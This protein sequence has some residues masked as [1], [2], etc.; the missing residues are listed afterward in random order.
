MHELAI[1]GFA[2]PLGTSP[3]Y[4]AQ[5]RSPGQTRPAYDRAKRLLDLA[6]GIAVMPFVLLI[7]GLC[8]LAIMLESRGRVF[9]HEQWTGAGGHPF[10][11]WKLRTTAA[12]RA[13][14]TEVG[15]DSL[16]H[17]CFGQIDDPQLTRLGRVLRTLRIDQLPRIF[18]VLRGEMSLV[19]P[20]PTSLAA[21]Q[22]AL[23]HTAR[24]DMKPGI[25]GYWQIS[26]RDDL[27][28]DECLR[29][30]IAYVRNHTLALDV[31]ILL[32]T[33]AVVVRSGRTLVK[34]ALDIAVA[35][36]LLVI[37]APAMLVIA[38]AIQ[39]TSPGPI[40]FRQVRIGKRGR[41]FEIIKFRTMRGDAES[42]LATNPTL[43]ATYVANDFKLPPESDPRITPFG[44]WLRI[45]SLDELPQLFNVLRGEMS[46]VG[47]RPIVPA[48][49]AHYGN[50]SAK[51]YS[52]LPGLTGAWQV[53]G[54]CEL[55]YP[56]RCDVE[57]EY[58]RTWSLREDLFI[59]VRTV[60]AVLS[61]RGAV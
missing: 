29:L 55:R 1:R 30:D 52:V 3:W 31:E 54:R 35:G 10:D 51:F 7:L 16:G 22:H 33:V 43:H 12:N 6:V 42:V 58:I 17:A 28:F 34:R 8:A 56:E 9:V 40:F 2:G 46:L 24:F 19:G 60:G 37:L 23:W 4:H 27:G 53:M 41:P 21:E 50:R 26:D 11:T 20:R 32:R 39:W 25:T 15:T 59:L 14:T 47:P 57:L 38:T 44:R 61:R 36:V 45:T 5:S 48:E 13:V 49:L 18:N